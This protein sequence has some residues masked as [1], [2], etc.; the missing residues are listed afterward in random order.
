MI[1]NFSNTLCNLPSSVLNWLLN[2]S[3]EHMETPVERDPRHYPD[4]RTSS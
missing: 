4:F 3:Q 1:Q 2:A